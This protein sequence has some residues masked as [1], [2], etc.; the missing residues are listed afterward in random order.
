MNKPN[1]NGCAS[2]TGR[3]PAYFTAET[4][5]VGDPVTVECVRTSTSVSQRKRRVRRVQVVRRGARRANGCDRTNSHSPAPIAFFAPLTPLAPFAR[6]RRKAIDEAIP[7]RCAQGALAA[8]AGHVCR[9][10]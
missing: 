3:E 2:R 1:G 7:V 6:L 4:S 9:V 10:P 8:A 5:P